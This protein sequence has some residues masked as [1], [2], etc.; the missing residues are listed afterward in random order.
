MKDLEKTT[1]PLQTYRAFFDKSLSGADISNGSYLTG[2][3]QGVL[4]EQILKQCG[5]DL[6]R[7]NILAQAKNLKDFVV[8]TAL[9]GSRSTT[10]ETENM[11]WTQMRLQRWT[12]RRGKPSGKCWTPRSS[13]RA[14]RVAWGEAV[15]RSSAG[16][17]ECRNTRRAL[18]LPVAANQEIVS[19]VDEASNVCAEELSVRAP[20]RRARSY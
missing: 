7:K 20:G 15:G 18:A 10:T 12:G 19:D 11:I 1:R 3:Q 14:P 8:P 2:Y 5:D 4:L 17:H 16:H 6:S 9:P 13:D